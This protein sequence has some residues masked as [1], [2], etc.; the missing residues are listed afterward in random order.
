MGIVDEDVERVRQSTDIVKLVSEHTQLKRVG[1]RWSG[2]CPFHN[3]K[4]GSFSV[5]AEEGLYHCFGCK[6]SGDA[7]TFVRELEHLDFPG[8]IEHLARK[9]GIALRYTDANEGAAR[10]KRKELIGH[11]NRAVDIYHDWLMTH[12]SAG[13]A[14]GYLRQR[15]FDGDMVRAYK[16]GYAPDT[17]DALA[18]KLK[19]SDKDLVD[20]GLGKINSIGKQMDWQRGRIV[21]PVFDERGDAVGFG[22]RIMPGG[23]GAKY[24]NS[25]ECAVYSKSRV[26]YGL[27]WAKEHIVSSGEAIICE[28]YTDVTGF[29]RAGIRRAVA[30]CGTALTDDHLKLLKRFTN[31]IVLAFDAD[32][33]GKAAA[34]R[35]YEWEQKY[36]IEVMVA[37]LPTG[38]DPDDLS[39]SDPERLADSITNA[40]SF[41]E[42]RLDRVLG[43]HKMDSIEHR[44]RAAEDGLALVAE[45]PNALV[46]DQYVM[47]I[48]DRCRMDADRLREMLR[49][50][51]RRGSAVA[52]APSTPMPQQGSDSVEDQAIQL[53]IGEDRGVAELFSEALFVTPMR[54]EIFTAVRQAASVREAVDM[55]GSDEANLLIELAAS[56]D[57]DL[58]A[59]AVA[60]RLLGKA[61]DRLARQ[62]EAE[63]R[64]T[65]NIELLLPDVKFL[66]QWVI[67]LREPRS[68]LTELAPLADWVAM[69]SDMASEA[70]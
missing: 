28:G 4:T 23:E 25:Q 64:T 8:A 65:G 30:T 56:S 54:R 38:V 31:R 52:E 43:R 42:F 35:V 39:R 41:L 12:P 53:M 51:R 1:R 40:L 21:F 36:E 46:R 63:A 6:K 20:S 14:R 11:V 22:G 47:N 44:A 55:L 60:S 66:R 9:A 68:D 10:N 13:E 34:D 58:N 61:A 24:I 70:A 50:P 33:A 49:N 27:N 15:G 57:D 69:K 18:K 2:L 26:L 59:S 29:G 17:W 62:L 7:I 32:D 19:I 48:A 5:N 16:V 45:H 3:E 67:D 37:D